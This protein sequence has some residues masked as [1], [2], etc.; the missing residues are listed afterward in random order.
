M[1]DVSWIKIK[2]DMFDDEKIK[3]LQALPEG[4]SILIIW[5]SLI[6]LAGKSNA[7]G[8][9]LVNEDLPYT[10]EM[11]ATI[12]RKPISVVR[13][14]LSAFENYGMIE[15]T[16]GA[17]YLVNFEKHQ[18]LDKL[19]DIKEYNRIKKREQRDRLKLSNN[20]Q[21]TCQRNVLDMSMTS[22]PCQDTEEDKEIEKDI[23]IS[24][25][26][27]EDSQSDPKNVTKHDWNKIKDTYNTICKDLPKIRC[28]DDKRKSKIKSL[29]N[30][31]DKAKI[32]PSTSLYQ[33]LEYIFTLADESDFLSGRKQPNTWCG[34]DWL[35]NSTNAIKVIEGNYKNQS[36]SNEGTVKSNTIIK[37]NNRFNNFPQ[38]T[39]SAQD[40][41][42]MERKLINRS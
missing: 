28:I 15:R 8:Y 20:S 40:Y 4:D 3:L 21:D 25:S 41:A 1:G 38:R 10:D 37:P 9:L 33:R 24:S 26:N 13:L 17:I 2:V 34:F 6:T 42:D 16:S 36:G 12:F 7:K 27:E 32:L 23:N 35:I 5:I 18:N 39:Y 30:A 19:N 22:Q 14:A 29:M 31:F 11:L